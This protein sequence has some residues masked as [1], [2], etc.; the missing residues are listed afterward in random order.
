MP[1]VEVIRP[2]K[3][4]APGSSELKISN[5]GPN[6]I[7]YGE[8]AQVSASKRLGTLT[9]GESLTI[10]GRHPVFLINEPAVG[11]E[12]QKTAIVDFEE[13]DT[14]GSGTETSGG[15]TWLEPA[16]AGQDDSSRLQALIDTNC[17]I[18]L[19]P[20]TFLWKTAAVNLPAS[21]TG[22]R[23]RGSGRG[24]T[25]IQ[26]SSAA[27]RAFDCPTAEATYQNI[28]ISDLTVD[29]NSTAVVF[30][31][32]IIV[33]NLIGG[34]WRFNQ[35]FEN[36]K[37]HDL[38]A[39]NM[40][41]E[42]S[43]SR[44]MISFGI[45]QEGGSGDQRVVGITVNDCEFKGG[46]VPVGIISRKA[47]VGERKVTL[48]RLNIQRVKWD[49]GVVPTT[50]NG[51]FGLQLGGYANNCRDAVIRDCYL[52]NSWDV[53]IE[54]DNFQ[55]LLVEG[56][57]TIDPYFNHILL[58]NITE[59]PDLAS[60][61]NTLRSNIARS[62]AY[63]PKSSNGGGRHYVIGNA[64]DASAPNVLLDDN[65]SAFEVPLADPGTILGL[66]VC[67][68]FASPYREI[69][70]QNHN[71]AA[72][73]MVV[74]AA[75][76]R[77]IVFVQLKSTEEGSKTVVDGL[78]VSLAGTR[79]HAGILVEPLRI[80]GK[81]I[82]DVRDVHLDYEG[83]TSWSSSDV[84]YGVAV[85]YEEGAAVIDGTIRGISVNG[86]ACAA[87]FIGFKTTTNLA[88]SGEHARLRISGCDFSSTR[89]PTGGAGDYVIP[90][91]LAGKSG[92]V[93]GVVIVEDIVG[94][95]VG[96]AEGNIKEAPIAITP[97]ASPY[98]YQN[99]DTTPQDVIVSGG[100]VSEIAYSED[101]ITYFNLGVIAGKF[102]VEPGFVLKVTYTGVP[103]M[104]KIMAR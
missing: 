54:C 91:T 64:S 72:P 71:I 17:D 21:A 19:S 83:L 88:T 46:N 52:A 20:G 97:G 92:G 24:V 3:V 16:G 101:A 23:I 47:P 38:G 29:A 9:A 93:V 86:S 28:E 10:T 66:S 2:L 58:R 65:T 15:T 45:N 27:L 94:R 33:G 98:A 76:A 81:T 13:K 18:L 39:I 31:S 74:T 95:R 35:N 48:D 79:E 49:S 96:S 36:I 77:H 59:P 75:A 84:L 102:R 5:R 89:C 73:S 26:L 103:T 22:V 61:R 25:T 63:D 67:A 8:D 69:K 53:A 85:G 87:G 32:H 55:K 82:V 34:E 60:Q 14:A 7:S 104:T 4:A 90:S 70:I 57:E 41:V 37:L 11:A 44:Q 42:A 30:N 68:A 50:E 6:T 78:H 43:P 51:S 99:L 62:V 100:T 12:K 40:P 1:A 80:N 56:N